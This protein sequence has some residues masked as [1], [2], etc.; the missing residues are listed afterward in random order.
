MT[1]TTYVELELEVDY[2]YHRASRGAR[3]SLGGRSGFG[4]ALEPD[5]DAF[6]EINSVTCQGHKIELDA[7][8]TEAL[9]EEIEEGIVGRPDDCE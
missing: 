1:L 3:D 8:Q 7:K 4:P 9:E 5:E 6:V 2:T